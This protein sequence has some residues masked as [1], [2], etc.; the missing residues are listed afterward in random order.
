MDRDAG[1]WAD[2]IGHVVLGECFLMRQHAAYD[3]IRSGAPSLS[4]LHPLATKALPPVCR[5]CIEVLETM[6]FARLA[7]MLPRG[8]AMKLKT[9]GSVKV[10]AVAR[11][12]AA[13]LVI[14]WFAMAPASV[15]LAQERDATEPPSPS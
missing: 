1:L 15:A 10:A 9:R 3:Q 8:P 2:F 11:L 5:T 13:T 7:R 4:Q 12:I 14:V 6:R